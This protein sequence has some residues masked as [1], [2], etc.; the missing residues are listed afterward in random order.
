MIRTPLCDLLGIDVPVIQAPFGPWPS[1][2]L[3]AAVSN[4]GG[5]GSLGTALRS[6]DDLRR[7]WA[8][9]VERTGGRAFAIN[10]T[11]RPLDEEAFGA[12]LEVRP[13]A[14]SFALGDPGDLVDRAHDAGVLFIQQVHTVDQAQR[15]AERGVD[16][17]VAQGTEAGGFGGTVSTLALV[18]QVV[19]AVAPIPVVAAGG[20]ADGRGLA[21]AL[22]LG[23]QGV[24]LGTRFLAAAEAEVHPAWKEAIV[25]AASE[26]AVKLEFSDAV[27]PPGGP[28]SFGTRPRVLRTPFVDEW[29]GRPADVAAHARELGVELLEAVR[30]GRAHELVPFTGQSAGLVHEV[31]PAAEILRLLVEHA[32]AALRSSLASASS[33]SAGG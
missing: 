19:D 12:S 25:S 17:I 2:E 7:E 5:L 4:A 14:V 3:S 22:V 29:N 28:G 23:A 8:E 33:S 30:S 16:V 32:E 26:D 10:H 1:L 27:F 11:A 24:N 18:P 20:I 15:V 9:M 13:R 31:L 6:L 21:A